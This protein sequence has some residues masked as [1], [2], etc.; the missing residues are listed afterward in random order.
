MIKLRNIIRGQ[1]LKPETVLRAFAFSHLQSSLP[2]PPHL[3]TFLTGE[4]FP[5]LPSFPG[6]LEYS[7]AFSLPFTL[8]FLLPLPLESGRA[9]VS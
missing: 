8:T 1:R 3:T 4:V 5:S 9:S 7:R 6:E 2:H